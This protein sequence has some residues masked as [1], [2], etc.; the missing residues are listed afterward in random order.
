M[1]SSLPKNLKKANLLNEYN[2]DNCNHF[3]LRLSFRKFADKS[4]KNIRNR[5][6]VSQECGS[7]TVETPQKS[8]I[9]SLIVDLV[10]SACK[11]RFRRR[12]PLP[13]I[14]S[15]YIVLTDGACFCIQRNHRTLLQIVLDKQHV[16][17]S[18]NLFLFMFQRSGETGGNFHKKMSL[19]I[20]IVSKSGG[21]QNSEK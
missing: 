11:N 5:T 19:T 18:F 7:E 16:S 10:H 8:E 14:E 2:N 9:L 13:L 12:G 1:Q 3:R 15:G 17:N 6:Q 4:D 21:M 20:R